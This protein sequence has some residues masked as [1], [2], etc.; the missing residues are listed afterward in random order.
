MAFD[1]TA[2]PFIDAE[3]AGRR[4][5]GNMSIH[6]MLLRKFMENTYMEQLDAA[7]AA[8]DSA[9][10][11]GLAHTIKGVGANLSLQRLQAVAAELDKAY[12]QDGDTEALT[13]L[14]KTV[15]GETMTAVAAY[16][17]P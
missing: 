11:A 2:F 14:L 6:N 13:A 1:C 7:L 4:M 17:K 10:A 16:L 8:G 3:D 9:E 5:A 15:H 12:K